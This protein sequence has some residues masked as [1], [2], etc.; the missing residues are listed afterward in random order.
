[1]YGAENHSESKRDHHG[2][3]STYLHDH[4]AGAQH[5]IELFRALSE[6]HA[7]APLGETAG[8]LLHQVAEDLAVLERI[9]TKVGAQGFQLKELTGWIADKFSRLKLAPLGNAFNAFEA[10]EFL[11]LGILGKRAL[12]KALSAIATERDELHDIDLE[13]LIARA[14]AQY[15]ATEGMRLRMVVEA[16]GGHQRS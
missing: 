3:L 9:A 11:G 4:T 10:L 7:G 1:M 14:E 12:W 6:A 5:A 8:E 16:F 15:A 13:R 2:A